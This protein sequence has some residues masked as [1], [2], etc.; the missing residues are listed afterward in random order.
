MCCLDHTGT[1]NTTS[2]LRNAENFSA[3]QDVQLQVEALLLPP[4]NDPRYEAKQ[5]RQ[6]VP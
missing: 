5:C 4:T 6:V 3:I 2:L 1:R